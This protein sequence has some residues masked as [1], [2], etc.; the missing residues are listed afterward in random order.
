LN[1]FLV[2]IQGGITSQL[3]F[4]DVAAA[5]RFK[6]LLCGFYQEGLQPELPTNGR[7]LYEALL[8]Q[9]TKDV[10]IVKVFRM[11]VSKSQ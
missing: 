8:G 11:S 2:I 1:T 7:R 5:K 4:H 9:W 10:Y 3:Q 6:H